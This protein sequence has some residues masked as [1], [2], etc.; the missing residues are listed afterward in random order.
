MIRHFRML[1]DISF[2]NLEHD[3]AK[4]A[5]FPKTAF[6]GK[7]HTLQSSKQIIQPDFVI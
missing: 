7:L 6:T 1:R 3:H 4:I 5:H 2:S